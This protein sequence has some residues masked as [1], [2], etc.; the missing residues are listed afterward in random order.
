VHSTSSAYRA[1]SFNIGRNI[2][3]IFAS[4]RFELAFAHTQ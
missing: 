1:L 4:T 3:A 2:R